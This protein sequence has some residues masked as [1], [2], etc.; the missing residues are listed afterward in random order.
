MRFDQMGQKFTQ[1]FWRL[2]IF[3]VFE[4]KNLF[5]GSMQ[6]TLCHKM[7]SKP[8]NSNLPYHF[9]WIMI[10]SVSLWFSLGCHLRISMDLKKSSFAFDGKLD[11][12]SFT[13]YRHMMTRSQILYSPK[14]MSQSQIKNPVLCK[15]TSNHFIFYK[16]IFSTKINP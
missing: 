4:Y 8:N 2:Y 15:K 13:D 6:L 10:T 11:S 7:L 12:G 14:I 16:Y 3:E 1:Q 9:V 5:T